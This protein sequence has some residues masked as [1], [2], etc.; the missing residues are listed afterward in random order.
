MHS[1]Y[2]ALSL[3]TLLLPL[4]TL[5]CSV[6]SGIKFTNYGYPDASGTPAYKC[7]G[8]NV[9]NT[10]AGDKTLL[11]DGSYEKPY[12]AAAEGNSVFKKCERRRLARIVSKQIDLYLIQSNK[13]IGQTGCENQFGTLNYG[14]PLHSV[15]RQPNNKFQV[16]IAPLFANG[17]C[18]NSPNDDRVFPKRDGGAVRCPQSKAADAAEL[19]TADAPDEGINSVD[20][21]GSQNDGDAAARHKGQTDEE[22][23]TPSVAARAFVA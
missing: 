21:S 6:A 16:L 3:T 19:E 15:I 20:N 12:A 2:L 5:S 7:N 1:T 4:S 18:F 8:N 14:S 11:G 10:V 23:P 22:A 13:K 17:K 9:V